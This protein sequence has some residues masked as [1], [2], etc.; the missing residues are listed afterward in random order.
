MKEAKLEIFANIFDLVSMVERER[1]TDGNEVE[2]HSREK[3]YTKI[4]VKN[5]TG[6]S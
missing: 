6:R 3:V 2:C 1:A 4:T 5:L